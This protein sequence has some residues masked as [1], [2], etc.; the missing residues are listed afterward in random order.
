[1]K[2]RRG[3]DRIYEGCKGEKEKKRMQPGKEKDGGGGLTV[4]S[5]C[6]EP[7]HTVSPGL[8]L[9]SH[10]LTQETKHIGE[11]ST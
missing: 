2:G 4:T 8:T 1:M 3:K 10:P 6:G 11:E 5:E 9:D 7:H